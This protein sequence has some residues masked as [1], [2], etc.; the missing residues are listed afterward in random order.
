MK[1]IL[2]LCLT[3]TV[4]LSCKKE[5]NKDEV[6]KD[7]IGNKLKE[8]LKNPDS[9]EFVSM[10]LAKSF[11]VKERKETV[12]KSDL[13]KM[14]ELNKSVPS[15]DLLHRMETEYSF[16]EKQSDENKTALYRYDFVAKGTNSFGG[17]IQSKYSADVLN[18]ENFTV[19]NISKND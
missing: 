10:T 9:F 6:I 12:T 16:L 2:L 15:E 14:R 11:T 5:I 18:D 4:L 7:N 8:R 17:V 3:F 13:E 19:L 1:K